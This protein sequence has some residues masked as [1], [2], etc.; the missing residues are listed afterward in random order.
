M[1]E[2]A[3][4]PV[5]VHACMCPERRAQPRPIRVPP[6]ISCATPFSPR[7]QTACSQARMSDV[8]NAS[9]DD[10]EAQLL[11]EN[12]AHVA[13]VG[14]LWLDEGM[15]IIGVGQD[16]QMN[17]GALVQKLT[18]VPTELA[19]EHELGVKGK[20][21]VGGFSLVQIVCKTETDLQEAL[22]NAS[23][24]ADGQYVIKDFELKQ[25][26]G[27]N[28]VITKGTV[29][30]A[31]LDGLNDTA[32]FKDKGWQTGEPDDMERFYIYLP[33]KF[34]VI[35]SER[36]KSL[37][38]CSVRKALD[39]VNSTA[40]V[41]KVNIQTTNG[42][43][44]GV[45]VLVAVEGGDLPLNVSLFDGNVKDKALTSNDVTARYSHL[46]G[47]HRCAEHRAAWARHGPSLTLTLYR[48]RERAPLWQVLP[49]RL[50]AGYHVQARADRGVPEE[51]RDQARQGRRRAAPAG[52]GRAVDL[53]R[54]R[55]H[56][57]SSDA[58]REL[59]RGQQRQAAA[60][61]RLSAQDSKK[62]NGS[63]GGGQKDERCAGTTASASA[64]RGA[65][66]RVRVALA[67]AAAHGTRVYERVYVLRLD[68]TAD[69]HV[70]PAAVK[71]SDRVSDRAADGLQ[72]AVDAGAICTQPAPWCSDAWRRRRRVSGEHATAGVAEPKPRGICST[73]A[74]RRQLRASAIPT[75]LDHG[76]HPFF[77]SEIGGGTLHRRSGGRGTMRSHRSDAILTAS[78]KRWRLSAPSAEGDMGSYLWGASIFKAQPTTTGSESSMSSC[79]VMSYMLVGM[80]LKYESW[81]GMEYSRAECG[82]GCAEAGADGEQSDGGVDAGGGSDVGA[83]ATVPGADAG[84]SG[85]G[86]GGGDS[87]GGDTPSSDGDLE[88]DGSAE[89]RGG[90]DDAPPAEGGAAGG[91]SPY[92]GEGGG[93]G[94]GDGG[95]A[96]GGAGG[97]GGDAPAAG[98][99]SGNDSG[100]GGGSEE[101][102][103]AAA[104]L[105]SEGPDAESADGKVGLALGVS[106][107]WY[108]A[109]GAVFWLVE[110]YAFSWLYTLIGVI[111]N[112]RETGPPARPRRY[113]RHAH[114]RARPERGTLA[115]ARR[116]TGERRRAWAL[117]KRMSTREARARMIQLRVGRWNA[118][119]QARPM[120]R[121]RRAEELGRER[122]QAVR[123]RAEAQVLL[124]R[125][126]SAERRAEGEYMVAAARAR[127][128][129]QAVREAER[130][131]GRSNDA[132]S[133]DE[134][135]RP[136]SYEARG[137]TREGGHEESRTAHRLPR[138]VRKAVLWAAELCC[139]GP[140]LRVGA[141]G[142]RCDRRWTRVETHVTR[143][144]ARE[145]LWTT[146]AR[147]AVAMMWRERERAARAVEG[148]A[149]ARVE[150]AQ[151]AVR[152]GRETA[153]QAERAVTQAAR[154]VR[155]ARA[156][157]RIEVM[158]WQ[159]ERLSLAR[160]RRWAA[161]G[162]ERRRERRRRER[163]AA[164]A[165]PPL[166][167]LPSRPPPAPAPPALHSAPPVAIVSCL[168][169]MWSPQLCEA[170]PG[171][172]GVWRRR[173]WA[174]AWLIFLLGGFCLEG[175]P[176]HGGKG[177]GK[178]KTRAASSG[179]A[180]AR[181]AQARRRCATKAARET[182]L[183]ALAINVCGLKA[184]ERVGF[185]PSS[186][187]PEVGDS[188]LWDASS[189][190]MDVVTMIR[191]G[192]ISVAVL[193]DTHHTEDM[194]ETVIRLLDEEFG[195]C[196]YATAGGKNAETVSRG[197]MLVWDPKEVELDGK[198][199][200]EVVMEERIVRARLKFLRDGR[201]ISWFGAYMPCRGGSAEEVHESWDALED[202]VMAE[203]GEG[204]MVV[205]GGDLN[206]EVMEWREARGGSTTAAD[207]RLDDLI[208]SLDL[209]PQAR[210]ATWRGGTQIDNW[211]VSSDLDGHLG[212]ADT[213]PGI[214]GDD[215]RG[216]VMNY[217]SDIGP[218]LDRVERPV[219]SPAARLKD[220]DGA[221]GVWLEEAGEEWEK[222]KA[223]LSEGAGASE[224][225]A[226]FQDTFMG[227]ARRVL[228]R[229]AEAAR[230]EAATEG[231]DAR[232]GDGEQEGGAGVAG[233]RRAGPKVSV[234]EKLRW[235]VAKW[236]RIG[237]QVHRWSG[238][239]V[240][241][242][243]TDL[244]KRKEFAED[245][246]LERMRDPGAASNAQ[247]RRRALAVCA[248]QQ[249]KAQAAFDKTDAPRGDNMLRE[250]EE[251]LAGDN[252]PC[253]TKIFEILRRHVGGDRGRGGMGGRLMAMIGA[254]GETVVRG[255]ELRDAVR[256]K[257]VEINRR[258]Q[259]DMPA[260]RELLGWLK[261]FA[262]EGEKP[263]TPINVAE[264]LCAWEAFERALRKMKWG[265]GMGGDGFDVYLVRLMPESLRREYH[266]ILQRV[267]REEDYPADWNRWIAMLAMKPGED[268]KDMG[269]RRDLWLQPQA[270]KLVMRMLAPAYDRACW[271]NVPGSQ[272]GFTRER[273][274]PEQTLVARLTVERSMMERTM[275]AN[276]F[277]D[278]G[279]FFMSCV[280][281][282]QW[283]VE[284]HCGVAPEV[285]AVM[286]ALR[287]GV[288]GKLAA[289][290]GRYETE[291]GLS[292]PVPI[293]R[294]LGQGCSLS[295]ARSKLMLGVM[296]STISKLCPGAKMRMDGRR[297]GSLW[298]ADD[299]AM[300][301]DSLAELRLALECTWLMT[302]M[303]G[304]SLQVKGK[305]KS[306]WSAV[307]WEGDKELDV[308]GYEMRMPDG[309][310]L[311][312][313]VGE[314]TY[315]YLGTEMRTGWADGKG[316]DEVRRKVVRKCRQMIGLIGRVPQLTSHQMSRAIGLAVGGTIGFYGRSS[317]ITWSDCA[318]IE[319]ARVAALRA[320]GFSL[321]VPRLAIFDT[322]GRGGLGHEHTFAVATAALRDQIDRA[323]CG[324]A[325]EPARAA[326]EDAIAKTC[327]RLGCRG[328]HPLEWRP[329]HLVDELR[330]DLLIEAY[331]KGMIRC[332]WRGRLTAGGRAL[333][334]PLRAELWQEECGA[335]AGGVRGEV[336]VGQRQNSPML[337]EAQC[338]AHWDTRGFRCT[339][340][341]LLAAKGLANWADV[342]HAETGEWLGWAEASRIYGLKEGREREEYERLL[343]ELRGGGEDLGL[344]SR[345]RWQRR[346]AEESVARVWRER[347]K[348]GA[349]RVVDLEGDAD[350]RRW[351]SG[352]WPVSQLRAAR[353]TAE[354]FGGWEYR[355]RWEKGK[356]GEE[357]EDTW[358][359]HAGLEARGL[360]E[361]MATARAE[362]CLPASFDEYL[363]QEAESKETGLAARE[364]R[365][366]A[367]G[368]QRTCASK[369][370]GEVGWA[371]VFTLFREHAGAL[372]QALGE[373]GENME[374][375][376]GAEGG[377]GR[378]Y[379]REP[380][381]TWYP[382]GTEKR[383]AEVKGE[384]KEVSRAISGLEP[385]APWEH[386]IASEMR[387]D[388]HTVEG[389]E[390]AR[391]QEL[392]RR[393]RAGFEVAG[394]ARRCDQIDEADRVLR[395]G[396]DF[397]VLCAP[398]RPMGTAE[399]GAFFESAVRR[400]NAA[401]GAATGAARVRVRVRV[402][403]AEG[404]L[405]RARARLCDKATQEEALRAYRKGEQPTTS[406][407]ACPI[408]DAA[409]S[410]FAAT[411]EA[412]EVPLNKHGHLVHG[413][414]YR[415]IVHEFLRKVERRGGGE[416]YVRV[417]Y[418]H[419]RLGAALKDAGLVA[420]SREYAESRDRRADPFALPKRLRALAT[421]TFGYDLDD[422][423]SHPTAKLAII[424][425]GRVET[426][427]FLRHREVIM[428]HVG[429]VLFPAASGAE[430]RK[431]AKM[432]F[433]AIDMDGS[434]KGF[435]AREG[436]PADF[437]LAQLDLDLG[438]GD[439]FEMR[440]HLDTQREGTEWLR[441]R[442][443]ARVG[444]HSFVEG[445]LAH[446]KPH[447]RHAERTLKSYTFQDAESVSRRAKVRRALELGHAPL[448]LQH[449]GLLLSLLAGSDVG[450]VREEMRAASEAA[451]GY[452]Q[453]VEVKEM[454]LPP[455][456]AEVVSRERAE[457]GRPVIGQAPAEREYVPPA[458][459]RL[460]SGFLPS[461]PHAKVEWSPGSEQMWKGETRWQGRA[462]HLAREAS[463]LTD[464]PVSRLFLRSQEF[465]EEGARTKGV[466]SLTVGLDRQERALLKSA[467]SPSR[468]AH[469]H[470]VAQALHA[471]HQFTH[472]AAGDG[473]R[474]GASEPED[475]APEAGEDR[476][477]RV[478]WGLWW[479]VRPRPGG[480]EGEL[481]A[482]ARGFEAGRLPSTFE[483]PDAETHALL[484]FLKAVVDE[485]E[486]EAGER[487]RRRALYLSDCKPAM[488]AVERAWRHGAPEGMRRWD[489]GATLEAICNLRSRIDRLVVMYVPAH[490]GVSPN[491]YADSAAKSGS[492]LPDVDEATA[493][494]ADL[495]DA[496]PC[497]YERRVRGEGGETT[498]ELEDRR[499][500]ASARRA[501]R[502]YVRGRLSQDLTAGRTTAGVERVWPEV[503]KACAAR[504]KPDVLASDREARTADLEDVEL[505][506]ERLA[507]TMGMRGDDLI[508]TGGGRWDEKMRRGGCGAAIKLRAWGCW[509]C[510]AQRDAQQ[511]ARGAAASA[512]AA[513]D[514]PQQLSVA[515]L[516]RRRKAAQQA[517]VDEETLAAVIPTAQHICGDCTTVT[518][519]D[520]EEVVVPLR[521]LY[522]ALAALDRGGQGGDDEVVTLAERALHGARE[523]AAARGGEV[524]ADELHWESQRKVYAAAMPAWRGGAAQAKVVKR[525]AT[526]IGAVQ[527]IGLGCV[528]RH[529][530]AAAAG[531]RF[532]RARHQASGLMTLVL[533][534]WRE[535]AEG[536]GAG[537]S[538]ADSARGR[539]VARG[540]AAARGGGGHANAGAKS[541]A[542]SMHA[543]DRR[544]SSRLAK[545]SARPECIEWVRMGAVP[546]VWGTAAAGGG[547]TVDRAELLRRKREANRRPTAEVRSWRIYD[548]C[549]WSLTYYRL[550]GQE[551]LEAR[552]AAEER[553]R[554]RTELQAKLRRWAAAVLQ[555]EGEANDAPPQGGPQLSSR[556]RVIV[557]REH[558]SPN[559]GTVD[560]TETRAY[561]ARK[562]KVE[563]DAARLARKMRRVNVVTG[564]ESGRWLHGLMVNTAA[565]GGLADKRGEG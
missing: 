534:A 113:P 4:G 558:F 55:Q 294:G 383:M 564:T 373:E 472:A 301:A 423:A 485:P 208:E 396:S 141:E 84:Q 320:R 542:I 211:L 204:R 382:G 410:A 366:L 16:R 61:R 238:R 473:S 295:P 337:W 465:E 149:R 283:E 5:R 532:A 103:A 35:D 6:R 380:F 111:P 82:S 194:D 102:A 116:K 174:T 503:T 446:H 181:A 498:W 41:E 390:S 559:G 362:R 68:E 7:A 13:H 91:D 447:R 285:T 428:A 45:A 333:R 237:E 185:L 540:G 537:S 387:V 551:A 560:T 98:G 236:I 364:R 89:G 531:L 26:D 555:D 247:R 307:Y 414:S 397:G 157:D 72:H 494:V 529:R 123:E 106:E 115:R 271:E 358:E 549:K 385:H 416:A 325:G 455:G 381:Q 547:E 129:S 250:M 172:R 335:L 394:S 284:A 231:G 265:K 246:G 152:E 81:E 105:E 221:R 552:L 327:L 46:G 249:E 182:V 9:I 146:E 73:D 240:G 344:R 502:G 306:A 290:E 565:P 377:C 263:S 226:R 533:R 11:K 272:A 515:A 302:K 151:C 167:T 469:T 299:G 88:G 12:A 527:Q 454:E 539:A 525:V 352:T 158:M 395:A 261:G 478:G 108:V 355:V 322:V 153:A 389:I 420:E 404:R 523:K 448:S 222:T 24:T 279:T 1:R 75:D 44:V 19:Y 234:R 493:I 65:D 127:V 22:H 468:T 168:P 388:E 180:E 199:A 214:C 170:W 203:C 176:Q 76:T 77:C 433:S 109:A 379:R 508:G 460:A 219:G 456:A 518:Q 193:A 184:I 186:S 286:R 507:F 426:A 430:R 487:G 166:S 54:R 341:R 266:E 360:A 342:T 436:I 210:G 476:R 421:A 198:D 162:R 137:E 392:K 463:A 400:L 216:V 100:G 218:V 363:R 79:Y 190:L 281:E 274:A 506:N 462:F 128:R 544:R 512:A 118:G 273:N 297:L 292:E 87:S 43:T 499:A 269:R 405:E 321:G 340:S 235:Q 545:P 189:K 408:D 516:R 163:T 346:G 18:G 145:A 58:R 356:A 535:V 148:A 191:D 62:S 49:L 140:R 104:A 543:G 39:Q 553:A 505:H 33:P 424:E 254:D 309:E 96:G 230:A 562:P 374:E 371:K 196:A 112:V 202:Q 399:V 319:E 169:P 406:V 378:S 361:E 332:G 339:F 215:H 122:A 183:R 195:L 475:E 386:A 296:Q 308:T 336:S 440:R 554:R 474:A 530:A 480:G 415:S 242:W 541:Q 21:S 213:I 245:A 142:G 450:D 298:Y 244:G 119:Q 441:D 207:R 71:I 550:V 461:A 300:F 311:P 165:P 438:G 64:T 262:N 38:V 229:R 161:L 375:V 70:A 83:D 376:C 136:H 482:L 521:N 173:P 407:L 488:Q 23:D 417:R 25:K 453:G 275:H 156:A 315:K 59:G 291:Y 293:E 495:V 206:S 391:Q 40:K 369:A 431:K 117:R 52:A 48:A 178:G 220:S 101:A 258:R 514:A 413:G 276:A 491:S 130:W 349:A 347:V 452:E 557:P 445:W 93:A 278:L 212:R 324:R 317:A 110:M 479:G 372:A 546:D 205:I 126:K 201:R 526:H 227:Q 443:E 114:T 511:R 67:A 259:V 171:E 27:E 20:I 60:R 305:R 522:E 233:P 223:S 57:R 470:R 477:G 209:V 348:E 28:E 29:Y 504:I 492:A 451:L 367:R 232:R 264:D 256:E 97:T 2:K 412:E 486:R 524:A 427:T 316:Q 458:H 496:R 80:A 338:D 359:P 510:K 411:D 471:A 252:G 228:A 409:L 434:W 95:G 86:L 74:P 313:L 132:G 255:A 489:R 243:E 467:H 94:G 63:G 449:D 370:E 179:D 365:E 187:S 442:L 513:A 51:G 155:A 277:C 329:D 251:V 334:G 343:L 15:K 556:G 398:A 139:L 497:I 50:E 330:D 37:T 69:M 154:A 312:Q 144:K 150:A 224:W 192:G 314:D 133:A 538:D 418:C 135:R 282:V 3:L 328:V 42:T 429:G 188:M 120:R 483:T 354:C 536:A 30:A 403:E 444:M 85:G 17:V 304:L 501:T 289:L 92:V 393:A 500:Y 402:R 32:Y 239:M 432:L 107:W 310:V 563:L 288:E 99:A 318:S 268:P 56:Q 8:Y 519:T 143:C 548:R 520:R 131:A 509:A 241:R 53:D 484:R 138:W 350:S 225:L 177:K 331:M 357:W 78:G 280:N 260:V 253:M 121:E 14:C 435:A 257:G 159:R 160:R 90:G 164:M 345:V 147:L 66:V 353:R 401:E 36:Q 490:D 287:E 457:E 10:M 124:Q 481:D 326:V 517:W 459:G 528:V 34:V 217:Y 419:S 200:C 368:A 267:V 437:D 323:L 422:V 270:S 31:A 464:D 439:R 175:N 197:V 425:P 125:A 248:E 303:L 466:G 134:G 384:W 47:R 561:T 351:Q